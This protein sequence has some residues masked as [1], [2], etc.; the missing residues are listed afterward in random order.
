M[1]MLDAIAGAVQ[2]IVPA[3]SRPVVVYASAWPFLR[4]LGR[5]DRAAVETLLS[6][7]LESLGDRTVLMPT[8]TRGYVDGVCDLDREPSITGAMTE[9]FRVRPGV[10][11]TLS[12]FFSFSVSGNRHADLLDLRAT[13]E[14]GPGSC[15]EWMELEDV[16]FLMLGTHPTNCSYLHRLE[17]LARDVIPFRYDKSFEGRLVREGIGFDMTETLFVRRL[18]PP[19]IIDFTSLEPGLR[20]AGMTQRLVAGASIATYDAGAARACVLPMLCRDPW[21]IVRN[22]QDYQR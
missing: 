14:W 18:D 20:D 8:F 3:D 4:Q 9:C 1:S 10:R 16:H 21:A 5:N 15:Y 7:A 22:R 17:W 19:V 11:R 12:A 2:E 13:H 6:C